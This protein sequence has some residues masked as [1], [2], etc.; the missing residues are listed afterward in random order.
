M[1]LFA[2]T[3]MWFVVLVVAAGGLFVAGYYTRIVLAYRDLFWTRVEQ[4]WVKIAHHNGSFSRI[5]EP[6]LRWLGIPGVDTLYERKMDFLKGVVGEDGEIVIQSYEDENVKRFKTTRYPYAIPFKDEEDRHGLPLSG[7]MVVN[8]RMVDAQKMF[9]VAS[10]WYA[11]LS[12]L[13]L[14]CF[15]EII[16]TISYERI[17]GRGTHPTA[18]VAPGA[19]PATPTVGQTVAQLLWEKMNT[20]REGGK[21]SVIAE[22]LNTYGIEVDS[23]ELASIDPPADWRAITLAPYKAQKEQEA[24]KHQAEASAVLFDDTN[25]ALTAW[26]AKNPNATEAQIAAKQRELHERA[27]AKTPGWTQVHVKGLEGASTAVIGG[28]NAGLMVGGGKGKNSGGGQPQ[29]R[30]KDMTEAEK[31]ALDKEFDS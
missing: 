11:T 18:P 13:I 23:V 21:L 9:Y 20:P 3:L 30:V 12:F 8:S 16:T 31:N 26:K 28:G 5:L 27:L 25:Q 4:G 22:L 19:A 10:D 17:T 14:A 29:K 2:E 24:A 6:G 15:R 1:S 7:V